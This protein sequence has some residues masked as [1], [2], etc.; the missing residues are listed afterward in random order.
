MTARVVITGWVGAG[1]KLNP[2]RPDID[3][4]TSTRHGVIKLRGHPRTNA[5]ALCLVVLDYPAASRVPTRDAAST[6]NRLRD[7][8]QDTDRNQLSI[9]TTALIA[10]DLGVTAPSRATIG[11]LIVLARGADFAPD[12]RGRVQVEINGHVLHEYQ[13]ISGGA[14]ETDPFTY[15]NGVLATVS[16]GDWV[17]VFGSADVVSNAVTNNGSGTEDWSV[18]ATTFGQAQYA[19]VQTTLGTDY[20]ETGV[21]LRSSNSVRTGYSYVWAQVPA[22]YDIYEVTAGSYVSIASVAAT[23]TGTRRLRFEAEGSALRGFAD[24]SFT[25]STTDSSLTG[26]HVGLISFFDGSTA[27]QDNWEGGDLPTILNPRPWAAGA[28]QAEASTTALGPVVIPASAIADDIMVLAVMLNAGGT[29]S[30]P[31]DWTEFGTAVN[32]ANQ[33]TAWFWKRHDGSETNPTTTTSVTM[34]STIGGYGRIYVFRGCITTG[35]PFEDVTMAG[36]PT[37]DAAP[38]TAAIDTTGADRLAVSIVMIDDDLAGSVF[39]SGYPPA[40][41]DRHGEILISTTGGD[42]AFASISRVMPSAGNV[43]AVTI[44]TMPASDYWRTI[45]FALIPPASGTALVVQD[46]TH[47]H[48]AENVALTQHQVLAVA[49]ATSA[50]TAANVALTQHQVLTVA[51]ATHGHTA[52]NVTLIQHQ[53]LTVASSTHG[54]TAEAVTL[55]Q[56]QVLAVDGATHGHT[57]ANVGLTQ[58]Q[59]LAVDGAVHGHSATNLS[60]AQ[61][62]TLV[63]ADATHGHTAESVTL[64]QHHV[65]AVADATHGHSAESVTLVQHHVLVVASSTHGHSADNVTLGVAGVLGVHDATHGHTAGNVALTQHQVLTVASST[66]GHTAGN[67]T[68]GIGNETLVVADATHAHSADNVTVGIGVVTLDVADSFHAH[69]AGIV[70]F[71]VLVLIG[72]RTTSSVDARRVTNGVATGRDTTFVSTGR[73]TEVAPP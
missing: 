42:A 3:R 48:T 65:L 5:D 23:T 11:E 16:G 51:D 27:V 69:T 13:A 10:T 7:L 38:L 25:I 55:T 29:F 40:L 66:H 60:L 17:T 50:H 8:G 21:V 70:A 57:A 18:R 58:H 30:T 15:S 44:G 26:S 22:T 4:V 68:L 20:C 49:N 71:S 54:H 67:I 56:H 1:T 63:V 73:T 52:A 2:Y 59:V 19:E 47:A 35:D 6:T 37:L 46:A 41:W 72:V 39:S 28:L 61:V 34:S 64:V 31:T 9:A 24:G 36:T 45:T 62:V 12:R 43:A 32:S 53:V 33:S 14:V